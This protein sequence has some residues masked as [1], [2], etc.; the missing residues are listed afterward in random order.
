MA[1]VAAEVVVAEVGGVSTIGAGLF[2]SIEG[3]GGAAIVLVEMLEGGLAGFGKE[4][5]VGETTV[6]DFVVVLVTSLLNVLPMEVF[7]RKEG[8]GTC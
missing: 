5:V 6:G 8:E 1:G 4:A 7:R 3:A 2:A